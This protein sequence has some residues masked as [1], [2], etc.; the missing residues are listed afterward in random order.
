MWYIISLHS[1]PLFYKGITNEFVKVC[2]LEYTDRCI[3]NGK[4]FHFSPPMIASSIQADGVLT[5]NSIQGFAT[6]IDAREFAKSKK[7][8][9]F[10]YLNRKQNRAKHSR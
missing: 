8:T 2:G 7:L 6:K 10:K 1:E 3:V 9:S 5:Q 4:E